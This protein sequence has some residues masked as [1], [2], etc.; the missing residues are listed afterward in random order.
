MQILE[1][2]KKAP[3]ITCTEC[4]YKY[5]YNT[6]DINTKETTGEDGE[7]TIT[8]I[9]VCPECGKETTIE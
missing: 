5:I 3:I 2:G 7:V 1:H 8:K 9:V 4:N 6:R